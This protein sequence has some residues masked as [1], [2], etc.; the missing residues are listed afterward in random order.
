MTTTSPAPA[1]FSAAPVDP[2][3]I[4]LDVARVFETRQDAEGR[5][6]IR[7][8]RVSGWILGPE[9]FVRIDVL[10]GE[11]RVASASLGKYR[12]D[13]AKLFPHL[14]HAE[15]AGFEARLTA[16]PLPDGPAQI[17]LLAVTGSGQLF[18]K[19]VM[20]ALPDAR[21]GIDALAMHT[22][23]ERCDIDPRGMVAVS[24]WVVSR[25]P[26]LSIQL[27][28]QGRKLA[29]VLPTL[30]RPDVAAEYPDYPNAERAGFWLGADLAQ[31]P[32]GTVTIEFIA[33]DGTLR[34]MVTTPNPVAELPAA[35]KAAPAGTAL[36][37]RPM[38][39]KTTAEPPGIKLHR[40]MP[41]HCDFV[42]L[43]RDGQ[44]RAAG[45]LL[46]EG[47][48]RRLSVAHGQTRH[49]TAQT[50]R[51]RPDVAM[52]HPDVPGAM[53]AG[54]ELK[55]QLPAPLDGPQRIGLVVELEDGSEQ[56]FEF[57]IDPVEG[58]AATAP[59]QPAPEA[60]LMAVDG[61]KISAN[62][63][64]RLI[65][66]A[67]NL[68]GWAVAKNGVDRV[69]VYLNDRLLGRAYH[70]LRREDVGAAYPDHPN[71]LLGGFAFPV[72]KRNLQTGRA[73][74]RLVTT[75]RKGGSA[76][77]EFSVDI[78]LAQGETAQS[79]LR[80]KMP[81]AEAETGLAALAARGPLP[82]CVIVLRV[83]G[84]KDR[85]DRALATLRSLSAQVWPHW[86]VLLAGAEAETIRAQLVAAG[87]GG[88]ERI[89]LLDSTAALPPEALA[90]VLNAGDILAVDGI[91]ARLLDASGTDLMIYGDDRRPDPTQPKNL[92]PC[93]K[94]GWSPDLLL[95]QNYIGRAWLVRGALLQRLGM[96]LADLEAAG[97]LGALLRLTSAVAAGSIRHVPGLM[98]EQG[99]LPET[100]A[101]ERRALVAHL[102]ASGLAARVLPGAAPFLHRVA[103]TPPPAARVSVIIPSIG[104]G[105][106]VERCVDSL[107]RT[108]TTTP[109]EIV[110]VD[111]IRKRGLGAE[112]RHW[113]QWFRTHADVVLEVD[114]PFNWSRLNNLGA[115]AASG[116][117]LL[118]LNDDTEALQP[119]WLEVLTAEAA[120]PEVGVV[121]AQLL[122]PDG[123]VQHAG[124]FLS[125]HQA[126]VARHAFR[127]LAGTDPGYFGLTLSQRNVLCLTGACM[128][129]RREVFEAQG[130]FDENHSVVNNDVD[131]SLRL[132]EAGL[133]VLYTPHA[134]LTHHEL[135]SRAALSDDFDT[136]GFLARW[137]DR[138]AMGDPYLNPGIGSEAEDY[139]LEEEPLRVV[140]A[141]TPLGRR[142][143]IARILAVKLDHIGDLVTALPALRRLKALFPEAKLTALV[144]KSAQGIARMEPAIDEVMPFE[145]FDARSGLGRKK[146]SKADY[147]A[148]AAELTTRRFD[149][150][151]DLRKLGDTRHILQLSGAPLLAGY[152]HDQ[153]FPW[154]DIALEWEG[155]AQ[156]MDKRNHVATDLL[157]L[158]EAV[159]TAFTEDRR[160]ISTPLD[161]LPPLSERLRSDFAD[162]FA[163][164]YVIVH[165]AAGTPLRQWPTA[166][167]ARLIDLLAEREDLRIALI[168]G[169]DEREIADKVL[170]QVQRQDR[171]FDLVGRSSLSE[172]PRI[173]AQGVLFVGN[174]SG[175]SHIASGLGVPTVAV[176]SALIASEEWGPL[177]PQAVALRRDMTCAPCY[178]VSAAQCPRALACLT[179]ITPFDVQALCQRYL[180][181]A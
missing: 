169:P 177:G 55:A 134:R 11:T 39:T 19:R 68:Q 110:I 107:R 78:D 153:S 149:L 92:I 63:A 178:I 164:R 42:T 9:P 176:H 152:D 79:L 17:I 143:R 71:S 36:S 65:T 96:S 26:I 64:Q 51:P 21:Q 25:T 61:M 127:F 18:V 100:H 119:D 58:G 98:L 155:D 104:A 7:S 50:G 120:R 156:Q 111:N 89:G 139:A 117:F 30:P 93:L 136:S 35:E 16:G 161:L 57:L 14:P 171:V 150:A 62:H 48:V 162:L 109:V 8:G 33:R 132:H 37:L 23:V 60:V 47:P 103:R 142:D 97:D 108:C 45:W 160:T 75:D 77:F 102:R 99:G 32:K 56:S 180:P 91:L 87:A 54:F 84:R 106:H 124:M 165:P 41:F 145:F 82:E 154:L 34:R 69:E 6:H 59:G 4:W 114:E 5:K 29:G 115:A 140:H 12:P 135:A 121:G 133:A 52:S 159:G 148:L 116:D 40:D 66:G 170:A 43:T 3:R 113:K 181:P 179:R 167:F 101:A 38:P 24:G 95:S 90:M 70:G 72:A 31:D 123:R 122:Y 173:I 144:G 85:A 138:Q 146:L 172:L 112:G 118:F 81:W 129:T 158:V 13:V 46:P 83:D 28:S 151:V 53:N 10:L 20:L 67:F 128:M 74:V 166:S 131:F 105:G 88:A 141:G 175:P 44:F 147:A 80:R 130:G 2:C 15:Y 168:G 76:S 94:P 163:H 73:Q 22:H 137:A 1:P 174:N 126:G 125:R 86:R 27:M 157:N 49:G